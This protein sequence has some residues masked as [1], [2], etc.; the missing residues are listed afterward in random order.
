MAKYI[1]FS[2]L[3][4]ALFASTQAQYPY[5]G[6]AFP[7]IYQSHRLPWTPMPYSR[8]FIPP[9]AFP[10]SPGLAP[11]ASNLVPSALY[12]SPIRRPLPLSPYSLPPSPYGPVA[13]SV[14]FGSSFA[15]SFPSSAYA[16]APIS[17]MAPIAPSPFAPPSAAAAAFSGIRF[18]SGRP[19]LQV[20]KLDEL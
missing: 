18:G 6:S 2:S 11:A 12:P 14:P 16:P 4:L 17:P 1:L 7:S 8:P 10:G 15:A 19:Q 3:A 20:T 13:N 9:M 5:G